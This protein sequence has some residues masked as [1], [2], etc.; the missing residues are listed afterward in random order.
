MVVVVAVEVLM[1]EAV[2]M[3]R[4][5]DDAISGARLC[6]MCCVVVGM[7]CEANDNGC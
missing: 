5:M 3:R 2:Q 7:C 1:A 6:G 4:T